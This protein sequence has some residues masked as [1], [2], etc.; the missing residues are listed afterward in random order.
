M[1]SIAVCSGKGGAGKTVCASALAT[2]LS[3]LGF[4]VLLVDADYSVA[5]LT[6]LARKEDSVAKDLTFDAIL[7]DDHERHLSSLPAAD[8][9]V[10]PSRTP[11]ERAGELVSVKA[12]LEEAY[13][14][15]ANFLL[16]VQALPSS[17]DYVIA[18]T[19]AGL[20]AISA[21][22]VL[23]SQLVVVLMEQDRV[24]F[25]SSHAFVANVL[26]IGYAKGL[27]GTAKA[28]D[29]YYV[30]NKV[31]QAYAQSLR[32]MSDQI[33]GNVLPGIP[34]DVNFFNRYFKDIFN[35]QPQGRSWRRT[36]FYRH[37][38]N[39]MAVVMDGLTK[40][41]YSVNLE[42][43]D[44]VSLILFSLSPRVTM[45]A[46]MALVWF[47]YLIFVTVYLVTRAPF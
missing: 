28:E 7:H 13:S 16:D 6:Y 8:I 20:D 42:I 9:V 27:V 41:R 10:I 32:L 47:V 12:S 38:R 19:R 26:S 35:Y 17:F 30:P 44:T 5:G 34:F 45:V 23:A 4:R 14:S 11:G 2:M 29:F 25:R 1:K 22:I 43:L 24:S 40:F 18:D 21:G 3:E 33:P 31:S 36:A 39:S 46:M 15:Y 37:L